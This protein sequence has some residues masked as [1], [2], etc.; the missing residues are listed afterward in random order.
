MIV[1]ERQ[2]VYDPLM[3][4]LTLLAIFFLALPHAFAAGSALHVAAE[5]VSSG[6]SIPQGAQ[7]VPVMN[8]SLRAPCDEDVT[9]SSIRVTHKGL[10]DESDIAR[11]YAMRTTRRLSRSSVFDDDQEAVLR[12]RNWKIP[13]CMTQQITIVADFSPTAA[14]GAEHIVS[15]ATPRDIDAGDADVTLSAANPRGSTRLTPSTMGTI[16]VSYP[17]VNSTVTYGSNRTLGRIK[18]EA[19]NQDDHSIEAITLTNDGKARNADLTNIRLETANRSVV[20]SVASSLD[21]DRARL[22]FNPPLLLE[23]NEELV[24]IIKA[25]VKASRRQTI[26]FLIEEPGDIEAR[27]ARKR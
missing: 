7:R 18:L 2:I 9:I 14:A 21:D 6:G 12:F 13:A 26:R 5:P 4:R 22:T 3:K 27:S 10:G 25:N 17:S 16:T 15:I 23:K 20:S 19:D 8:L 11:V 24:F 1:W